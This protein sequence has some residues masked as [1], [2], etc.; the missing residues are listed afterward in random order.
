MG[1]LGNIG[2]DVGQWMAGGT[3]ASSLAER[4]MAWG[5]LATGLDVGAN[6]AQGVEGFMRGRYMAGVAKEGAE[7][8]RYAGGVAE[9]AVKARTTRTIAEQKVAQAANNV[10]VGS[11]TAESV[12]QATADVGALDAAMIHYNT[13]REAYGLEEQANLLKRA[14]TGALIKGAVGAG[15]SFL[16]GANSL[17]DKWL[18]YQRSGAMNNG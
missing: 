1:A 2:T 4:S 11:R 16:S 10:D 18:A 3:G 12:R 17:A 6:V 5:A 15:V 8:A 9:S 13:A 14:G 7:A